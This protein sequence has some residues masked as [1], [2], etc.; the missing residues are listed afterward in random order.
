MGLYAIKLSVEVSAVLRSE[1]TKYCPMLKVCDLLVTFH[2]RWVYLCFSKNIWYHI[3]VPC[4]DDLFSWTVTHITLDVYPRHIVAYYGIVL[5]YD[6]NEY[7]YITW[8]PQLQSFPRTTRDPIFI[9]SS[10]SGPNIGCMSSLS[11]AAE[12][13]YSI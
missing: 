7:N 13:L 3:V 12:K 5:T 2:W 10:R 6:I 9:A 8:F 4:I 1:W 11:G